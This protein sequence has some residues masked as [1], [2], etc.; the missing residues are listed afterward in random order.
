MRTKT[1]LL[2]AALGAAGIATSMAQVF[3]VNAVGYVNT[4]LL[5]GFNLISNPLNNTAGNT[6]ENLFGTG[7]QAGVPAGTIVYYFNPTTDAFV[8]ASYEALFGVFDPPTAASQVVAPGEGVFVFLG[9]NANATVTFVG[10]VPQGTASN[11]Q[12]PPGFS[13]KGSTVPT[14]GPITGMNFPAADGDIVYEWNPTTDSYVISTF[15]ALFGGWDP[16]VPNID[17]G[18]AFW[19]NKTGNAAVA[20]NRDFNVN[21]P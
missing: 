12:I 2:T 19:V 17:V 4:T 7:F 6:I 20:W 15:Q 18:E 1:L 5:P 14:A 3:S 21:Q 10:E 8:I 16:Q 13:I 11:Q 9:G